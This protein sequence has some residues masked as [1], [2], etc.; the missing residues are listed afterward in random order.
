MLMNYHVGRL[1]LSSL[2]VGAFVS[3][4]IWWCSFCR[5]KLMVGKGCTKHVGILQMETLQLVRLV[6]LI[7]NN[8]NNICVCGWVRPRVGLES[9]Q[10]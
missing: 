2:C 3:V 1:V 5:L 6:G 9:L 7:C 10:K 4:G 8:L